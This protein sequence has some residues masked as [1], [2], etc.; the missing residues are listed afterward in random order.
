MEGVTTAIVAFLL[1][2]I[3]YPAIV[4]RK[5]MY[6][7]AFGAVICIIFLTGMDQVMGTNGFHSITAFLNCMLQVAALILLILAAGGLTLRQ[8]AG[9]VNQAID[10]IRHDSSEKSSTGPE[11]KREQHSMP[12]GGPKVTVEKTSGSIPLD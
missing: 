3:V 12:P 2:C 6:Y 8:L 11:M 4:K 1:V 7:A 5:P 9:E 10:S